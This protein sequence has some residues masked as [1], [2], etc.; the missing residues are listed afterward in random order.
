MDERDRLAELFRTLTLEQ[1]AS[2]RDETEKVRIAVARE[3]ER[4]A[5][6]SVRG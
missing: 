6:E 1:L 2:L 3:L 5:R 4:R